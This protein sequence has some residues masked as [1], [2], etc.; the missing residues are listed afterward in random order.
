MN[1]LD[2]TGVVSDCFRYL[3]RAAEVQKDGDFHKHVLGQTQNLS[4]LIALHGT[5]EALSIEFD[6]PSTALHSMLLGLLIPVAASSHPRI[7][8]TAETI[9]HGYRL[10]GPTVCA[11][12]RRIYQ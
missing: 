9:S 12:S 5:E 7:K 2:H 8:G 6:L 10:N 4:T 3:N 11:P 1:Q